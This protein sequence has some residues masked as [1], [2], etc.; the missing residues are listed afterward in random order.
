[1]RIRTRNDLI[2]IIEDSY[3]CKAY[4]RIGRALVEGT[5]ENLGIFRRIPCTPHI[6]G[7]IVIVKGKRNEWI[8][9]IKPQRFEGYRCC[10]LRE[11]PWR[12][13]VGDDNMMPSL[14]QGDHPEKYKELKEN[15]TVRDG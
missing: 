2:K 8:V 10:V 1:M 5:N 9:A 15:E 6:S 3:L 11:I 13:W 12:Y 7:W 4:P 14:F